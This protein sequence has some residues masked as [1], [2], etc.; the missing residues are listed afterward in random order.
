MYEPSQVSRVGKLS[1]LGQ[2]A[3]Y[4]QAFKVYIKKVFLRGIECPNI[5]YFFKFLYLAFLTAVLDEVM[6]T[7]LIL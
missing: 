6:R 3:S 1:L 7:L 4:K 5:K 2:L